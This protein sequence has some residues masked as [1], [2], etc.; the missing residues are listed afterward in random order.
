MLNMIKVIKRELRTLACRPIYWYCMVVAPLFCTIFFTTLMSEGLPQS[1]PIGVVDEDNTSTTRNILRNLDAFQNSDIKEQYANVTE[2]RRAV[3]R[4]DIYA[5][6]YIPRGT[7]VKVNRQESPTVS[8][9]TNYSYLVAGSLLYKD[10]RMMSELAAGAAGRKVLFAKGASEGQAMAFL[11]PIVIDAHPTNNP[12]LNYSVYLSSTIIPGVI[13]LLIFMV[14]VFSIGD[15]IKKGTG[16]ELMTLAGGNPFVALYGKLTAHAIIWLGI[17]A[18]YVFYLYGILHYPCNCGIPTMMVVMA[19]GVIAALGMGTFMICALPATRLGL[20]FA[21]LWGVVS[22][23]IS[24]MSFPVMGMHPSL[25]SLSYLF[26]LRHYHL[27]YIN[28]ALD[29]YPLINGWPFVLSLIAFI[30]IPA[31]VTGRFRTLMTKIAY[32]Q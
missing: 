3:Q 9:Y 4:G 2:A 23:S 8:F 29:G 7:T 20:S 1:M 21:S 16:D 17:G 25:Q 14:T 15:E 13:I 30:V 22:F 26:P 12:T 10:M 24:G 27:L 19:L 18:T 32:K 6:Y 11:Q 31:L 28:C 5:F